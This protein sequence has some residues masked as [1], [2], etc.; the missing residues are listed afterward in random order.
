MIPF[1][2]PAVTGQELSYLEEAIKNRKLC[3]DGYFT[4]KCQDW[5][6]NRTGAEQVLLTPSCT[7]ALEMCAVLMELVPGDEVILPSYTFSSTANAFALRGARL[8]FVDIDPATMNMDAR[9]VEQAITEQTKGIIVVHYAGV[10]CEMA[11]L[12]ELA[13][14]HSLFVIEDAAQGVMSHYREQPLGAIGHLGCY[15]FHET[16]NIT[17]GEGGALL[18]NDPKLVERAEIIREKG[19]NR[20]RFI[21]GYVDKYS[22]V[23]IGSSF[24]PSELNAAFLYA[25]LEHIE[26]IQN[27]RLSLWSQYYEGLQKVQEKGCIERPVVP[28]HC[29]HNAHMFYIKTKDYQERS[30]LI[31]YLKDR[32]IA[33]TFHYIPLHSSDAGRQLGRFHGVDRYT[34]KESERLL[35]LPL[36]YD[37]QPEEVDYIVQHIHCFYS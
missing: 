13:K 33:A 23:D 15:S 30:Q 37:L 19:T 26:V 32:G 16:K 22:W 4:E 24:L 3:G 8:V 1:N 14:A 35:R 31:A 6:K 2:Q 27:K 34:T 5:I 28:P 10:A 18:I 9:A 11:P 7:H 17:S 20:R 29:S 12:M 21:Q 25:Q 36:Y